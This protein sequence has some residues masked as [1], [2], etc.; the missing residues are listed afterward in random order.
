MD[1]I[2][3]YLSLIHIFTSTQMTFDD[4]WLRADS[5]TYNHDLATAC[6]VLSAVVNS[7]SPVSYTHLTN[8]ECPR[9]TWYCAVS[10]IW[11]ILKRCVAGIS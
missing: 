9:I 3:L 10:G 8:L 5:H 4:A 7:E 11:P 2:D 6:A 1:Y